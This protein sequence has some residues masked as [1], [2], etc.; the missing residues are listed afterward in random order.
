MPFTL[1][2]TPAKRLQVLCGDA[3]F[4]EHVRLELQRS[5]LNNMQLL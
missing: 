3:E 1:R 4:K 2:T 5:M